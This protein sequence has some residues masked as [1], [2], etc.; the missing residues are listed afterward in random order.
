MMPQG[1]AGV[2][3][4]LESAQ[5]ARAPDVNHCSACGARL[6]DDLLPLVLWSNDAHDAWCY[7]AR[8]EAH[9]LSF[10]SLVPFV[11]N[12]KGHEVHGGGER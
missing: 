9:I 12:H 7:C 10:V 3:P 1:S 8:C 11:V 2:P 4:A 5:D 6:S